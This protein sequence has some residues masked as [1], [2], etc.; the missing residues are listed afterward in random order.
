M[1]YVDVDSCSGS[2]V[3]GSMYLAFLDG[4]TVVS[5]K[6]GIFLVIFDG[7]GMSLSDSEPDRHTYFGVRGP[8]LLGGVGGKGGNV[9]LSQTEVLAGSTSILLERERLC[10]DWE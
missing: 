6:V 5:L 7:G 9:D 8:F 1:L 2:F 4:V 10:L 3:G